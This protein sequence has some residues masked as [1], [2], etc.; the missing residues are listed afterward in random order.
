MQGN[1]SYAHPDLAPL[2]KEKENK[3]CF[4]CGATSPKWASVSNGIYLCINCAGIHRGLGVHISFVRSLTMDNWD[5]NQI[6][7]MQNAGNKRLK[8]FLNEYGIPLST[9]AEKKYK[10]KAMD[11]YRKLLKAEINGDD[12][13]D[14]PDVL[15]AF[16]CIKEHKNETVDNCNY[17]SNT[18]NNTND[19]NN[20]QYK[21]I[22]GKSEEK[23][24]KAKKGD[25]VFKGMFNFFEKGAKTIQQKVHEI[26]MKDIKDKASEFG[27]KTAGFV[28][29]AKDEMMVS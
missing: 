28:K 11:Y 14:K 18:N 12:L 4:D 26:N 7:L 27:K 29:G 2:L 5:E 1:N 21:S 16:E 20:N 6:M 22:E 25:N 3:V 15:S 23:D 24:K 19:N 8:E 9:P 17:I 13:P 10:Y